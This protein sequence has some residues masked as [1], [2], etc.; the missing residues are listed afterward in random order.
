[1]EI[2]APFVLIWIC[3]LHVEPCWWSGF[4]RIVA[5]VVAVCCRGAS[6]V[7]VQPSYVQH[8]KGTLTT[9]MYITTQGHT[10]N[11]TK[12]KNVTWPVNKNKQFYKVYWQEILQKL[13]TLINTS[14]FHFIKNYTGIFTVCSTL[15]FL[16]LLL[17]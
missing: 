2:M 7:H 1:M 15:M 3:L 17:Q 5:A 9:E 14:V 11:Q 16:C 6:Q 8:R 12:L 10:A 4:L 13:H